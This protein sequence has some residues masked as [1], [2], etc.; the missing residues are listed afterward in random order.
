MKWIQDEKRHVLIKKQDGQK[1]EFD[2]FLHYY[3]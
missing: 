2:K 3:I 1:G